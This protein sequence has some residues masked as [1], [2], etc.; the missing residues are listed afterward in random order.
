MR[1]RGT[2]FVTLGLLL[3]A[4]ALCLTAYNF[5]DSSRAAAQADSALEELE[6]K[7][8]ET[9]D[10][11]KPY[12]ILSPERDM[13]TET[14]NGRDYIGK[15]SLPTLGMELPV[16]S[17]WSYENLKASP[18]RYSGSA[19]LDNLVLAAHN[20]VRHFG[21]IRR[22]HIGDEVSFMDVEGNLFVYKVAEVETLQP[23]AV[24]E[25]I[26]GE[27]DLTLFTCTLGGQTRVTVRCER[28]AANN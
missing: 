3:I 8:V 19:Y 20:Y 5:W 16:Q 18:C 13:P 24:E 11:E 12:Y 25:M 15:L 1:K 10:G 6:F 27:W 28:I 9:E 17:E 4:A 26:S 14:V 2:F 23:N 21:P 7:P 22:L